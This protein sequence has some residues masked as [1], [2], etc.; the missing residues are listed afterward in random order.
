MSQS[1]HPGPSDPPPLA[2]LQF[3][4]NMTGD[5]K[6]E[7]DTVS[8]WKLRPVTIA[9]E[10][11]VDGKPVDLNQTLDFSNV[12]APYEFSYHCTNRSWM[13]APQ[14]NNTVKE[15]VFTALELPGFQ[16]RLMFRLMSVRTLWGHEK[17]T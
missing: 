3:Q 4:A 16:V 6:P 7:E 2:R 13:V 17:I 5:A 15:L 8:S 14:P 12:Y 10:G 1:P 11:T 9:Y